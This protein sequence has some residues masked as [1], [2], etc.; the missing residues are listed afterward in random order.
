MVVLFQARLIF[1]DDS[2][3]SVS[4]ISSPSL[5]VSLLPTAMS[6]KFQLPEEGQTVPPFVVV[7]VPEKDVGLPFDEE[8]DTNVKLKFVNRFDLSVPSTVTDIIFHGLA[9]KL[10]KTVSPA[11]GG[12]GSGSS[13]PFP[14]QEERKIIQTPAATEVIRAKP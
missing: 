13:P 4:C 14:P 2:V 11:V 5:R 1:S 10:I 7:N 8:L 12:V 9:T 6:F 3:T